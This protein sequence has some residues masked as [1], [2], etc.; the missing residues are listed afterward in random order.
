MMPEFD[1]GPPQSSLDDLSRWSV[2]GRYPADLAEAT[3][4][5]ADVA[6]AVA[7]EVV[8]AARAVLEAALDGQ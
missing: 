4:R 5:D 7:R 6:V 2:E 8:A 3:Q 1:A